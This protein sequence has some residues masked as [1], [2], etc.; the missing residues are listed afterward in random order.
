MTFGLCPSGDPNT[1]RGGLV[2]RV[3]KPSPEQTYPAYVVGD[4]DS[5]S[6]TTQVAV[7]RARGLTPTV[8]VIH[9]SPGSH[10]GSA[11]CR[12]VVTASGD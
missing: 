1:G 3:S 9:G 11:P 7:V 6:E 12:E 10:T 2:C 8:A 5:I 4:S